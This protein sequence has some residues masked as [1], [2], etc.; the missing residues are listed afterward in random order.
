MS[1]NSNTA[2]KQI[3]GFKSNVQKSGFYE[4]FPANARAYSTHTAIDKRQHARKRRTLAH[5]FSDNS[6]RELETH[7]QNVSSSFTKQLYDRKESDARSTRSGTSLPWSK[8][9]DMGLWSN[10]FTFDVIGAMI[11]SKS[12]GMLE[13][14]KIRWVQEAIHHTSKHK[15]TVAFAQFLYNSGVDKLFLSKYTSSREKL[16]NFAVGL[17]K[18]R[19][20]SEKASEKRDFVDYLTKARDPETGKGFTMQELGS[21]SALLITAGQCSSLMH[22]SKLISN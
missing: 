15:Y 4:A 2:L 17:M 16:R 21:E 9:Y 8:P 5:G 14:P 11:F 22:R 1:I 10:N 3:Y 12:F 13:D 18:E 6:L 7:I 19:L 20:A